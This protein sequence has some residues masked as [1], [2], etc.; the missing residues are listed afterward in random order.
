MTE[1]TVEIPE[2]VK[3]SPKEAASLNKVQTKRQGLDQFVQTIIQ[4]GEARLAELMQE[5]K[6]VWNAIGTAHGINFNKI[7]YALEGEELVPVQMKLR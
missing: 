4:Q 3:L 2:R 1:K 7:D 5:Q 6:D